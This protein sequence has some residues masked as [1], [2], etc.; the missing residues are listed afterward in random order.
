MQLFL[1]LVLLSVPLGIVGYTAYCYLTIHDTSLTVMQKL[2]SS[3]RQSA[4]LFL[5][6]SIVG[7]TLLGNGVLVLSDWLTGGEMRTW[8]LANF[9]PELA[10][11]AF[12]AISLLTTIAR[13]RNNSI[14]PV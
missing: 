9:T 3:T 4:T 13:L 11:G 2:A 12:L 8:V 14:N 6:L 7:L 5:H 1:A 10:T